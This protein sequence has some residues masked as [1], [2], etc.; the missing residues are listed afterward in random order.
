MADEIKNIIQDLQLLFMNQLSLHNL[1]QQSTFNGFVDTFQDERNVDLASSTTQYNELGGYFSE[2]PSEIG[3]TEIVE[4]NETSNMELFDSNNFLVTDDGL[5]IKKTVVSNGAL[6]AGTAYATLAMVSS[7]SPI[8]AAVTASSEYVSPNCPS[9]RVLDQNETHSTAPE[10]CWI[11]ALTATELNP[12]WLKIDLGPNSNKVIN[13]YRLQSR[14]SSDP[15]YVAAPRNF[16]LFGSNDDMVWDTLDSRLNVPELPSNTW[17]DYFTFENA[18]TYRYYQLKITAS[19]GTGLTSLSQLKLVEASYSVPTSFQLAILSGVPTSD[20]AA[21][22][23]ISSNFT[24][25]GTSKIFYA[26]CFNKNSSSENWKIWNG[27]D[28]KDIARVDSNIWQYSDDFGTWL[29]SISNTRA[30]ALKL[31]FQFAPNQMDSQDLSAINENFSQVFIPGELACAMGMKTDENQES[32]SLGYFTITHDKPGQGLDL[33]SRPYDTPSVVNRIYASLLVKNMN[34]NVR[35]FV[36]LSDGPP[37]WVEPNNLIETT[38]VVN[39]IKRY[40]A[41][42]DD[43]DTALANSGPVRLRV[44]ASAGLGIEIHGWAINWGS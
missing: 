26:L 42:I 29:D 22:T 6:N 36:G 13:K 27:S 37:R 3:L 8:P 30:D 25:P 35:L 39:E 28:W 44:T 38:S 11:A 32:P 12:Q 10:E 1:P 31:A 41:S 43:P 18:V 34:K 40:T 7:L 2:I 16:Q 19:W 4:L 9:W 21:V 17:S 15:A 5:R 23:N 14:N 20:W 33:V 24:A